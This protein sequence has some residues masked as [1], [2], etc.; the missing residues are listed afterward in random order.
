MAGMKS[1]LLEAAVAIEKVLD[2]DGTIEQV[3]ELVD[4]IGEFKVAK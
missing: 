2:N 4:H 1:L 3:L